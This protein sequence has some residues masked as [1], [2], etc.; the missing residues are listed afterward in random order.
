[1]HLLQVRDLT[2]QLRSS[3][4]PLL[5]RISFDLGVGRS[6][7]ILGESGCGKTTLAKALIRL[8]A[9]EVWDVCGSVQFCG[10]E[11]LAASKHQ[12]RRVR[13]A[14]ISL[15][16][17]EPELALSP[18]LTVG[19]QI[20]EVLRAHSNL[21]RKCRREEIDSML[22]A[23]G[24]PDRHVYSAYPH[25]LSGG[26]R[27]RIV[28]AQ[29]LIAKPAL[30]IADEPT[31]ALDNITRAEILGL[32]KRLKDRFQ[33]ALL[34]ITHN[35]ALLSGLADHL[36]VMRSGRIIEEGS[37]RQVYRNPKHSHAKMLVSTIPGISHARFLER[38]V[39]SPIPPQP[40]LEAQHI[41]KAYVRRR[42][43][44]RANARVV[45]LENVQLTIPSRSTVALVGKS[46]AGKSTLGRCI[47]L[48]EVP[49]SGKIH[50]EGNDLLT[51]NGRELADTRR[52][53]QFVFQH[54]AMAMNPSFS[55]LDVVAEPLRIQGTADKKERRERALAIME[56]VGIS[57]LWA[58]RSPLEFSGGQRQRIAIARALI[59][60]PKLLV[61]DEALA[62]LDPGTQL[63]IANLLL[64]LQAS[65]LLSYLFIS[66][67][68]QM[69]A[70]L[71][72]SIAVIEQG[73]IIETGD[74]EQIFA[75]AVSPATRELVESIPGF[76]APWPAQADTVH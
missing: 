75:R 24:L 59:L 60:K 69:A 4:A 5:D 68:L 51:L 71:S 22:A 56:E 63:Q 33:L 45:A 23:A 20:D 17:Q 3:A 36:M 27:Q 76:R 64:R 16:P 57:P 6:T 1:M 50:F 37:F 18:V 32:L 44:F 7:G 8:L 14:Q 46:G 42:G 58:D 62:G 13:G 67:D 34:F 35:P 47:A 11:L 29:S 12:L 19:R 15:I 54:S 39:N 61:L 72:S 65:L 38:K 43:P 9:P 30:L 21:D 74:V 52:H 48:L 53:V 26:Q 70:Y 73:R 40:L 66:H 31:S 25:E 55:M 10:T 28:I 41:S 49:D 2:V